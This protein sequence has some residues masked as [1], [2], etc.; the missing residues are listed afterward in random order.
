MGQLSELPNIGKV[1][2]EKCNEVGINNKE[3]LNDIGS[4]QVVLNIMNDSGACIN[5]LCA[6]ESAIQVIRTHFIYDK[7]KQELRKLY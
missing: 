7:V 5:M 6:L 1:V 2:E 3:Q 4:K